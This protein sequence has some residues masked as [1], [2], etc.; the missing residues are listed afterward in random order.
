LVHFLEPSFRVPRWISNV[1]LRP[2][3]LASDSCA[4]GVGVH[5]TKRIAEH[6]IVKRCG[7]FMVQQIPEMLVVHSKIKMSVSVDFLGLDLGHHKALLRLALGFVKTPTLI[8]SDTDR[9]LS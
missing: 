7:L 9:S 6:D 8:E 4:D 2:S 1:P 3:S 5:D